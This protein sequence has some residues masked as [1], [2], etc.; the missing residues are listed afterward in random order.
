MKTYKYTELEIKLT[1]ILYA[2]RGDVIQ[3][4]IDTGSLPAKIP[5]GG[6]PTAMNV[7]L[8][9]RGLSTPL[10]SDE[11]LVLDAIKTEKSSWSRKGSRS[12]R[13]NPISASKSARD[14][15]KWTGKINMSIQH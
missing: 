12:T 4:V 3:H 1:S 8:N 10:S 13:L 6:F 9:R 5:L 2:T 14:R 7:V 11:L 15:G